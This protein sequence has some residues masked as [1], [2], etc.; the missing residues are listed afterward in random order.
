MIARHPY[1]FA[2][3]PDPGPDEAIE[4]WEAAKSREA[5]QRL[6][7]RL[8][9]VV[10]GVLDINDGAHTPE[11]MRNATWLLAKTIAAHESAAGRVDPVYRADAGV[12][13]S[14]WAIP[15]SR[16]LAFTAIGGADTDLASLR[17]DILAIGRHDPKISIHEVNM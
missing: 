14:V 16:T 17:A 1:V 13:V 9:V 12:A 7:Q 11:A 2:G 4:Q 10:T 15:G 3:D 6:A 5:Q 8:G